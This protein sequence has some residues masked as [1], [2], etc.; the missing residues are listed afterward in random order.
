MS[1]V[2]LHK[3]TLL[4]ARCCNELS[5]NKA[6]FRDWGGGE[7]GRTS[8]GASYSGELLE[9]KRNKLLGRSLDGSQGNYAD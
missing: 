3:G 7:D 2:Y 4:Y 6:Y 5:A 1:D 9:M 8:R